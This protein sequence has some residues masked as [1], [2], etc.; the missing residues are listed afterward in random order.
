MTS[1]EDVGNLPVLH[2]SSERPGK[3]SQDVLLRNVARITEGTAMG[4]YDRT[5]CSV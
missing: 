4:E 1:L 5:T 2:A 3:E